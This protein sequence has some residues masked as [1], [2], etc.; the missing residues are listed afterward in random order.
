MFD[1]IVKSLIALAVITYFMIIAYVMLPSSIQPNITKLPIP[2]V[3]KV[4]FINHDK[5]TMLGIVRYKL[6]DSG[7]AVDYELLNENW[8]EETKVLYLEPGFYGI[9]Q[10]KFV[11]VHGNFR[12]LITDYKEFWVKDK[13]KTIT[14]GQIEGTSV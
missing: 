1:G 10:C 7:N 4:T 3:I 12:R 14:F 6:D 8:I 13:P 5:N 11:I 2:D 9:T